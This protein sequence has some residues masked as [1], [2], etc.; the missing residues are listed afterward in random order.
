[1]FYNMFHITI[2]Y[3]VGGLTDSGTPEVQPTYGISNTSEL[4]KAVVATAS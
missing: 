4:R 2:K 3:A 1:M